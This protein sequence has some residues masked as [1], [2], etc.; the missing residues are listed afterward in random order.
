MLERVSQH[1]WI[2]LLRGIVAIALGIAALVLPGVTA[3]VLALL[4]GAYA[5]IDGV[6]AIAA[7]VRMSH[8]D[9][10]WIW[11]LVEGIAGVLFGAGALAFPGISLLVLV[12]LIAVWALITGVAAISTAWQLRKMVAGEWFWILSGVISILFAGWIV[13]EPGA[14]VFAVVYLFGFYAILTGGAFVGL[15]FRLRTAHPTI[16]AQP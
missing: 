11:L 12:T 10:R 16:A 2:L 4:F 7:S 13:F 8:A 1:W 14:G 15:A 5:L 6:L 9:K 3:L